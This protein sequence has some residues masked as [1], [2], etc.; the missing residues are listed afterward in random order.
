MNWF[1]DEIAREAVNLGSNL[2]KITGAGV[3]VVGEGIKVAAP[4]VKSTVEVAA[5]VIRDGIITGVEA[6]KPYAKEAIDYATPYINDV[7]DAARPYAEQAASQAKSVTLDYS[8]QVMSA[9]QPYLDEGKRI[10]DELLEQARTTLSSDERV[11]SVVNS[12]RAARAG[13]AETLRGAAKFLD[14]GSDAPAP[15]T[16]ALPAPPTSVSASLTPTKPSNM[17]KQAVE[18]RERQVE[19]KIE[20][21]EDELT[22]KAVQFAAGTAAGLLSLGLVKKFF[23]PL[24][25]LVKGTLLSVFFLGLTYGA[26]EYG[27]KAIKI[28]TI[29]N[30][31]ASEL[32]SIVL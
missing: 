22:A 3:T 27:P 13:V 18:A 26:V 8:D 12:E 6:A 25:K 2:V 31:D 9:M 20:Q 15:D 28:W 32:G 7:L 29:L 16:T 30:T 23:E 5:P 17:L 19:A 1:S 14:A 4:I 11:M 21:F 24:E 10:P